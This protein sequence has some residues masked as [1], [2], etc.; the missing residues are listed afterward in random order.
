MVGGQGCLS[1]AGLPHTQPL[2]GSKRA[3]R[4]MRPPQLYLENSSWSRSS[5][6]EPPGPP[7]YSRPS[8]VR[9][10]WEFLCL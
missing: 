7:C 4:A 9:G 1:H 6:W 8:A 5:C 10:H 2:P 3:G